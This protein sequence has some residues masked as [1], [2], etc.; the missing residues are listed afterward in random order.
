MPQFKYKARDAAGRLRSGYVSAASKDGAKAALK[1]MRLSPVDVKATK[2]DEVNSSSLGDTPIIGSLVYK[3]AKGNIQVQIGNP[4]ATT[5]DIIVFTKQF[6]TMLSSGVPMIQ[7]ISILASQQRVKSFGATLEKIRFAVENGA[8][9]SDALE[10]FPDLFDT[11]YVAMV[12]AGEASGSLDRILLKLVSYIEKSDKI[13]RQVKSAMSYP[14]IVLVAAVGAVSVL[15]VFVVPTLAKQFSDNGKELPAVTSLVIGMSD[16][17]QNQWYILLAGLFAFGAGFKQW[18]KTDLGRRQ[19]DAAMLKAPGIGDLILKISVGR[20]CSTMSTM[21]TSGVNLLEALKIC[22]ASAGNKT[23]ESFVLNIRNKIEEGQKF[24]EP[25]GAG[26][27]FPPM[28]VS[29]VAIGEQ[30]G[31]LDEMLVKVSEFYEDEVDLAVKTVLGMI[32]PIMIIGLGGVIGFILIAMYLPIF[33][34]ASVAGE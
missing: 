8:Q 3:D 7:G 20:F 28:V 26:G 34:M 17:L 22:A 12:R 6:S 18:I 24:S 33:D 4:Q 25:L 27:L 1:K 15:L 9:L 13:K 29:M 10:P 21:L 31:A 32:E 11:L 14:I 2:L 30:S 19:F 5:K 16:F 23:I